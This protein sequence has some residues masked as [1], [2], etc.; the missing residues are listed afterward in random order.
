LE[1]NFAYRVQ[2]NKFGTWSPN[3]EGSYRIEEVTSKNSYMV[4]S[5]QGISLPRAHIWKYLKSTILA[6]GKTHELEM[7]D[8][9][10]IAL[11]TKMAD[12]T[13]WTSPS[14]Q[15]WSKMSFNRQV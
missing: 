3:W 15:I 10:I 7:V 6:F 11:S 5:V 13:P 8:N 14:S 12:E 9:E 2:S 1:D 4:Q